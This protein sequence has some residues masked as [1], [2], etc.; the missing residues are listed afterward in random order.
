[1]IPDLSQPIP[2]FPLANLVFFPGTVLPLHLFE[3]RYL[4]M[5]TDLLE[6]DG[7]LALA[8]QEDEPGPE[9]SDPPH[10]NPLVT[11]GRTRRW[12]RLPDG[13]IN[14]EVEGLVR[15]ELLMEFP[16]LEYRRGLFRAVEEAALVPEETLELSRQLLRGLQRL[17]GAE[18]SA[19]EEINLDPSLDLGRFCDSLAFL[20]PM[21]PRRKLRLLAELD[22]AVRARILVDFLE[23]LHSRGTFRRVV[24]ILPGFSLN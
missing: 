22:P 7:L 10:L 6:G 14:V 24:H 12:E 4:K 23:E 3:P 8:F 1:V 17:V 20:L 9:A 15:A 19:P 13:A 16:G 2:L 5:A 11:V 18:E 21:E